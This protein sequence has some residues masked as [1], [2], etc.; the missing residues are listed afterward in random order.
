MVNKNFFV[1]DTE[2][3]ELTLEEKKPSTS[4]VLYEDTSKRG[5]NIKHFRLQ[6]GNFMAVMYDRPIHKLN[7]DTGKFVDISSEVTETD[8]DYEAIMPCF[9][10]RLPKTEGKEHFVTVEKDNREISWKF[11]PRSTSR[12][13][14]SMA[15]FT[16]KMK[17]D[18]WDVGDHPSVKYERADTNVDLE[19]DVSDDGVKESIVLTK[20]PDCKTFTFQMKFKGLFP[21]LS[22]DKKVVSLVRDDDD[23]GSEMPEMKIPPAYMEDAND[24][25]CDD[26]HYEIRKTDEGTFL[27]L[28]LDSDW[29]SDPERAYPV[30]I[31]PR[32]EI[33]QYSGNNLQLVE[34]C[35]NGNE[36]TATDT[37]TGRRIGVD[38]SGNIHRLY[39]GFNLPTLA[40]GFKITKAGLLMHQKSH[41]SY[42]GNIED[43]TIAPVVDP[44]GKTLSITSFS[45]T[46][47]QN[48][49]M[50]TAIDTLRGYCRRAA[51]E[52]EI[53]MTAAMEKWYDP[54][55]TFVKEKCIVI[56]KNNEEVCC[57]N[58]NCVSTYIDLYSL[59]ASYSYRPKMYIE[60][61]STDMY[62]DHQKFHTFEN[63]R[64]GTGSINL[65]TGKMSFAHGDVT[66]EG[67][68][69]PLSI[70]HL[71]RH[72]FV[73]EEQ[74][75]INRYGKGWKLSVEQ[76]LEIINKHGIMAVYTNAQGKRHYFMYGQT[77]SNGEFTDD[78]GLGLTYNEEGNCI[79]GH[80]TTHILTDEK[81][82][83]MTFNSAGKLIQLIDAN[84]NVSCL[85]YTNGRLSSVVDGTNHSA[86]LY[87]DNSGML[88]KIVD[89][90]DMDRAILYDYNS[91]GELTSITY[92]SADTAY[93]NEGTLQTQFV[94]GANS[95]LEQVIDYTGIKYTIGYDANGRVKTL[96]TSGKTVVADNNVT[97]SNEIQDDSIS[98]EYRAK[99]T[100][101][102][103][104]RTNI[105]TVYKFDAN[106][107]ELSSYQDMTGIAD[108][109]KISESTITEISGYES[110]VDNLETSRIGKYRS[111]SVSMSND[112]ADETN[113][114]QNGFFTEVNS[115]SKPIGW[116]AVG[117]GS[118]VSQS[119]INGKKS[120]R[121]TSSGYSKYLS[122][123]IDLCNCQ[124]NGNVLVASAWAKASGNVT[125][126]SDNSSAKFRLCLKVTY[127]GGEAEEH[128]E[129]YD[130]GYTGWQ[131]AAIPFVLNKECC[132]ISITVKLDY[133]GNTGTCYFTNARL[134]S[135][136]GISTTNAYRTDETPIN[137]INVFGEC[138]DIKMTMTKKDSVLTTIDY[139]DDD[140]D[141]V[142]TTIIDRNGRSYTT[143]Y[144]YDS[145]HNLIKTQD[146]RGL[147]IEYTYNAY[148]KELTRKTYHKD[149]P[150]TYMF[151]EHTYQDG[152]FVKTESDP[153]YM[154][155]G[156]KLKTTYQHD[157]S[158]N[159]LL[160]QTAVNGQEYN[161]SY[162][163]TTDD[164]MSLSST[165]ENKTNENQFFYTRGYLTRV[166]HNGFNFGFAFDQFGRSKSVSVGDAS[167]ST[168][169]LTMNYEK[170]G[171][172]DITE[173]VFATGE[174][175]RVTTDILG[176]PIVSKYTDKNNVERIISNATYDSVGKV[177][178]LVDNE[179]GV[180]YNYTYDAKGNVTKIV[181]TDTNG[182]I[183]ATN[184][185]VFDANDRLTSKTY[186]AVG[187]TYRPVYEKNSNGYIYPDN[188]VLG[189]TL[190]G[191]FTDK[192]TKDGL[193]RTSAKTFQVGTHTLFS[194]S[195]GYLSTPKDGKT[196]ATEIVSSVASHVYGTSANSSTLGYTYDKA[197]N[198]ETI[199][200]GTSLLSKYYYDGLNRLKREDNH[201]A[202]K[203]YVWDYDVGGNI[204]FKKEYALCTDVNLG[205]CLDTK[206]YT[207]KSEGWRDRL[208]SF[209]GQTC[210]YDLMGNPLTYRGNTLTWT[211]VRR[212]AN[213]G[214]NTFAY[215]ANGLRYRKNNTVY[216]LDGNKILR[217]SDGVRTL[218]YY[219]GGSGIIGFNYNG[220][221]YYFRK[222]LQ[223][224]VTEIYTSA[225]L[226]VASYAYDAWGKV[227]AVNNYTADNIGD[228]NPIRYRSYYYDVETGLYYLNSRYYD[229]EVG[230]FIN[231]DTTDV[232]EN[233]Q[234][235]INGLNLYAYCDNNPVVGRDDEGDMSFWKKLA[236]A[237]AVVVAVAVVA[238]VVCAT[239]GTAAP[240]CA[241]GTVLVGAAKGAAIG[242]VVGAATG[243][244]TGA[245]QGA[246][247]GYQETGTLEGTLRGMGRGAM[248]GA[249]EGAKDGLISGMVSG[250]FAGAA[251]SM[252]GNPMFCFV[253]GTTVLTTLGKKAI[254]TIQIGDKIP[255]VDHITGEAAE[256]KVISTSVNK[257]DRLIELD[258]DGEIIQC[259]ETHP[260][261]VKGKGWVNAS[262]LAPNDI[263]YTKNWNTA[264]VKSVNLLELDEPVEVF[265]FEVEDCH[266]YFVGDQCT[267]VHNACL[268]KQAP[269]NSTIN[270]NNSYSVRPSPVADGKITGYTKH[271]IESAMGHD[272][273][274]I[275]PGAILDIVKNPSKVIDQGVR[276]TTK[277]V[278][279]KGAVILNRA[280][281]IVTTY[282]KSSKFWR[283]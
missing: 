5:A 35:S 130:V 115:S 232:L 127:E 42:N 177:K 149:S 61:T 265:N 184:T 72:E 90:G 281:E 6:N 17:R 48:L 146:Y 79:C 249:V 41:A 189:I 248:K 22:E 173:T 191:K 182:N 233:A 197:G 55:K 24:A 158:R 29:L 283:M 40:D 208:D 106:G 100:A 139:I 4:K 246:V 108:S 187:H 101:I 136:D 230:R 164:L 107:R 280:G 141:I 218:T 206:T 33:S 165:V 190:D 46:N 47:V 145:K 126:E 138:K 259:T 235:N 185:F 162:D 148:G 114:I 64:A 195:Y 244:A 214:T 161:Y 183:L 153:R 199:S 150:G 87:Y 120:Y 243:A 242:A 49:N 274:G 213:F 240:L 25:F 66:A 264:T 278:S 70:S 151:S 63:G 193:R 53:D 277:Y 257:V 94:Y 255:C 239:A 210:T 228:L 88:T 85:N 181:E 71:Y 209:D 271:G 263:V 1:N 273:H 9:K 260:F 237:A 65:F 200:N 252:S 157:T 21:V 222:N 231:A 266:T 16:H 44:N 202:G 221:D 276:E 78:A 118:V 39:I 207:Y 124:L 82:N 178:Q 68:K 112:S 269:S 142:R 28:V 163:D 31:D 7:P 270:S 144:K 56:K 224:D 194:E 74:N 116:S 89:N 111:L 154:L 105:K 217:E 119:Y 18:P 133:T 226:K 98:F 45:W 176:N 192:V 10:V 225:G 57:Y 253:A 131:Y 245:V 169:L 143:D 201:T 92:P 99:S 67:V 109:S 282:A 102:V 204:L 241:A 258:I 159:L 69:L 104:D 205:A 14:K 59:Y 219:H 198:L 96:S 227:L 129:N 81:G 86:Q 132:P 140:S 251:M 272:N 275:R 135:V 234:Y 13:K 229:P 51:T 203:T 160:K 58:G 76:T 62:S 168:T 34:L 268:N 8:T 166:A 15:S 113:F 179:R 170:D 216:T 60:Y 188:E 95:R 123:T 279:Q 250:A 32:V 2:V 156:E 110:I 137:S 211:K 212:L 180:C 26:I 147:V 27:D 19:Y 167:A 103:N 11:I 196:I 238:A 54:T 186:G 93:S 12:R 122:Q 256:K 117:S 174:K 75:S 128:F 236:I 172:N 52:I 223:G 36:V 84:G 267:L 43:Y 77:N 247:E 134:V 37:N 73:N 175:N 97:T 152:S 261:Q 254:E 83:K 171:V 80:A 215:G 91:A 220:T 262:D 3:E 125:A 20:N 50:E 155:N 121:F 30:V 38:S 23:L